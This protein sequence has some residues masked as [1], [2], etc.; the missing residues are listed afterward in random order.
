MAEACLNIDKDRARFY[1]SLL[2]RAFF[3]R[4]L[5]EGS[6][7]KLLDRI[8]RVDSSGKH[9]N[10]NISNYL[11]VAYNYLAKN[12]RN[13]YVYKNALI[14]ELIHTYSSR[15][16][17]IFSEFKVGR[18]Y[19]DLVMFNGESRVYEIKTELDTSTRL[20]SQ[21]TDYRGIFQKIYIVTHSDLADKYAAVDENLGIIA[22]SYHAGSIQLRTIR[23]PIKNNHADACTIMRTLHTNEYK[24]LVMRLHGTLPSVGNFQMY[25]ACLSILHMKE[26]CLLQEE[27]N[28]IIKERR[29]VTRY[30]K[31]YERGTSHLMQICLSLHIQPNEYEHLRTILKQVIA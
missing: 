15:S 1:S 23:E 27:A 24:K 17:V 20:A 12:Y 18:S 13:E 8:K 22:L 5:K 14:R 31:R 25:D 3:E 19:A 29:S 21:L 26:D 30:L 7:T 2:S 11:R 10:M 6:D 28:K 16:S 4:L 9:V